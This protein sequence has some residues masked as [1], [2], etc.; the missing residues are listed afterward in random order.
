M[1]ASVRS[2]VQAPAL[3]CAAEITLII[4]SYQRPYVWPSEDVV[5]L[6]EQIMVACDTDAPHYYIGTVL[7]SAVTTRDS[8]HT[9]S[10]YEVIDG[11]QRM[12]T[13][14]LLALALTA[15]VPDN[16]LT[17]FIV[18]NKQ[19]RLT[20]AI[21][22]EVQRLFAAWAGLETEENTGRT[23]ESDEAYIKHLAAAR[24]ALADRLGTLR[25]QRGE[26]YLAEVAEYLYAK[27]RWVNNIMPPGMD[28]NRLFST[29]NNSGVQLEHSD[30][31]KSRLL[32]VIETQKLRFDAIWQAC[33][34][35]EDFFERNLRKVFPDADWKRLKQG[36]LARH[37]VTTFPLKRV[38]GGDVQGMTIAQLARLSVV[39]PDKSKARQEPVRYCRPI[40]SF[41]LLLMHAYRIYLKEHRQ[42]DVEVRLHD[43]RLNDYFADFIGHATERQA[44]T[45]I[46]CLWAVRYQFDM[47][48]VKWLPEADSQVW[49]LRQTSVSRSRSDNG[50]RLARTRL[51]SNDLSQLQSV[52]NFTGERSAQYWLTP[53]LGALVAGEAKTQAQVVTLMERIDNQL[54]LAE[55]SQKEASF[56]LLAGHDFAMRGIDTVIDD[57]KEPNGTRFEHYWFQ[58]LEYILWRERSR[59]GFYEA[60]KLAAYRITSKNSVEHVHPQREEFGAEL[61]KVHLDSFGNLVLL[62]P[63]ENS[64][65]SNQR[66][67]KKR[68]DFKGKP[69]YDSL[70][71]AHIFSGKA[72]MEWDAHA[73]GRHQT[74]ML[75]LI[76]E[77]YD[78]TGT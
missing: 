7:T 41:G 15:V 53:F 18:W 35:M 26:A 17:K 21:R 60:S 66:V 11:Q 50:W 71:L 65:Y 29:M 59:F 40:I 37:C 75:A 24:K 9:H 8:G 69:R 22:D 64:S 34:N 28:L 46:E 36:D 70:K 31:L 61:A 44:K 25:S 45:F 27:V 5:G 13:L 57:L 67:G 6:L 48:V 76:K 1:S 19:P 78:A 33:E 77:H 12:T 14:M 42:G 47:W 74:Q 55:D 54:S 2:Y 51:E 32:A 23:S 62:S 63:G 30:I 38:P 56:A 49:N 73:I 3:L 72:E 4:P 20:F 10:L 16:A 58:K 52:R 68:E 43:S 39:E